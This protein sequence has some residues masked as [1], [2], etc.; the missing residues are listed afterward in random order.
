MALLCFRAM[1]ELTNGH[2][3]GGFLL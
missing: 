3:G 1:P 2:A